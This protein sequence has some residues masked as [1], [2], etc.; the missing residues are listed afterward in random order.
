MS[1]GNRRHRV[2]ILISGRGSNMTAIVEDAEQADCPYQVSAVLSNR[3]QA[4]GLVVAEAHHLDTRVVDHRGWPNRAG[5]EQALVDAIDQHRPHLVVLAGFM[6]IL[7]AGFVDHYR[8]RLLNIHPS[9][10][11]SFRGLDTHARVLR[12]GVG[13]H[14][15]SVH[16]VTPELD[17]GPVVLQAALA[18]QATDN[19]QTL[20]DRVLALEHRI[21]P[22]AIRWYAQGRLQLDDDTVLFDG[23][24]LELPLTLTAGQG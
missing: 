18:V 11:P 16:F 24:R 21:Y 7:G 10:L 6:R 22:Q 1:A 3:P 15:A 19:A 23:R 14:G 9:L 12:A 5:F 2:V 13:R 17:G 8:G 20:A 4:A